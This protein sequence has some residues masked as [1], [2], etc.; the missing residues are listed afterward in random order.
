VR[1]RERGG[2]AHTMPCHRNLKTYIAAY[3]EGAG[4]ANQGTTVSHHRPW[5][6]I[7][8]ADT[9]RRDAASTDGMVDLRSSRPVQLL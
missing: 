8:D 9:P 3:I 6:Q 2:K 4:L 5:H 1:L 7:A